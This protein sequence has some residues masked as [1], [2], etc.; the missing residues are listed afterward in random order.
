MNADPS[1]GD[2]PSRQPRRRRRR[3]LIV[4]VVVVALASLIGLQLNGLLGGLPAMF[5]WQ[6]SQYQTTG[7]AAHLEDLQDVEQLAALFNEQD[8][9]PRLILLLSPT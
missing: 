6:R 9:T 5:G 4:L 8:D 7:P 1:T 2:Q 3:W